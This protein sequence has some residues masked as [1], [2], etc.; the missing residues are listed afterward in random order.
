LFRAAKR[1]GYVDDDP[2]QF[3]DTIRRDNAS[4][5]RSLTSRRFRQPFRSRIRNGK[6]LS[7]SVFTPG[8]DSLIIALLRWSNVDLER[9]ET[10]FVTRKTGKRIIL[11]MAGALRSQI[12]SLPTSDDPEAPL[13][14][15]AFETVK[16]QSRTGTLSNQ[17]AA[18]LAD[19]GCGLEWIIPARGKEEAP[20]DHRAK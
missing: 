19:A 16:R 18:F 11:P 3:V 10:R 8:N 13:H 6:V 12:L 14:P 4:R 1:D 17:F 20:A 2:A 15:R 7:D 5:R 9:N